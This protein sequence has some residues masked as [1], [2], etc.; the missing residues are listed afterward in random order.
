MGPVKRRNPQATTRALIRGRPTNI[1]QVA[2]SACVDAVNLD[3]DIAVSTDIKVLHTFR[4]AGI[5]AEIRNPDYSRPPRLGADMICY[6][7]PRKARQV[8]D[9]V[10]PA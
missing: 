10:L 7:D 1:V 2:Q 6:S 3:P 9:N 4:I 8:L 5:I